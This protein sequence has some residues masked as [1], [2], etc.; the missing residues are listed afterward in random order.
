MTHSSDR[1]NLRPHTFGARISRERTRRRVFL[2]S[3][4]R[5]RDDWD[6]RLRALG[7]LS[8][9]GADVDW[10][11]FEGTEG[12]RR[13]PVPTYP[14]QRRRY[15]IDESRHRHVLFTQ[16]E[17]ET[18][19]SPSLL[20]RR[21]VSA[22]PEIQFQTE[23]GT[24]RLPFL[25]DHSIFGRI[26][27]PAAGFLSMALSSARAVWGEGDVV[28]E[29]VQF[30]RP[31]VLPD[32]GERTA[33]LIVSPEGD[34]AG[35]FRV[36]GLDAPAGSAWTLHAAGKLRIETNGAEL[37]EVPLTAVRERCPNALSG[38]EYFRE[39]LDN[40]RVR[41]G[42]TFRWL[43]Q[44]HYND[45]EALCRLRV[46]D[47]VDGAGSGQEYMLHPG[48]IDSSFQALGAILSGRSSGAEAYVPVGLERLRV[49]G[50][51]EP[52]MWCHVRLI[53]SRRRS[54]RRR[55]A[56]RRASANRRASGGCTSGATDRTR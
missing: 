2:P 15:T 56:R 46:P 24:E 9:A 48:L 47:E 35:S 40:D 1:A 12:R 22:L 6:M 23:L 20:G 19:A 45:A 26:V 37:A 21:L 7:G 16:G 39:H 5:G 43:D 4:Q 18:I 11:V 44:I 52:A 54:L 29:E 41:L 49:R 55:T 8:E 42:P 50:R 28:L 51:A 14:F 34:S 17:T 13:L 31:L 3:L 38:P 25:Q 10:R 30:H 36:F 53:G 32:D 27:V 33:Q